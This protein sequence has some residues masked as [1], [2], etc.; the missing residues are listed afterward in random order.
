MQIVK[1]TEARSNLYKLIDSTATSHEP[2]V[3]TG[4][5]IMS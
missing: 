4:N 3:I 2:I 5:A 1:A